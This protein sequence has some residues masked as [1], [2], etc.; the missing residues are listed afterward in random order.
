M[1]ASPT[2]AARDEEYGTIVSERP[3]L[4]H[5][6]NGYLDA[7]QR[8]A[9]GLLSAYREANRAVRTDPPPKTFASVWQ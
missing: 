2:S 5:R 4:T 3:R 7:L 1:R 6:Y 9:E 8:V